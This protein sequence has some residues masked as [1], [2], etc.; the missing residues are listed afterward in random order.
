[1]ANH[2]MPRTIANIVVDVVVQGGAFFELLSDFCRDCSGTN[3]AV[4]PRKSVRPMEAL[5]PMNSVPLT[6]ALPRAES[7]FAISALPGKNSI[8]FISSL[9]L[10]DLVLENSA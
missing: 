8:R 9:V 4:A 10:L 3:V 7:D 5:S 1:M 6:S 2:G